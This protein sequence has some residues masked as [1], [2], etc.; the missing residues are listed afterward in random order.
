MKGGPHRLGAAPA[1]VEGRS[2]TQVRTDTT[3]EPGSRVSL[4]KRGPSHSLCRSQ[5]RRGFFTHWSHL[6]MGS[7]PSPLHPCLPAHLEASLPRSR[8]PPPARFLLLHPTV[9]SESCA[10]DTSVCCHGNKGGLRLERGAQGSGPSVTWAL[11]SAGP[12]RARTVRR[13]RRSSSAARPEP[14]TDRG[15]G[16]AGRGAHPDW[17]GERSRGR[18]RG[19]GWRGPRTHGVVTCPPWAPGTAPRAAA[20]W[21]RGGT[22]P[23]LAPTLQRSAMSRAARGSW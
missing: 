17:R 10:Y 23:A 7:L 5:R 6:L 8:P 1:H 3:G 9:R 19:C 21:G 11:A 20:T 18:G 16:A 14:G 2:H 15:V 12:R 13:R 4:S 22:S